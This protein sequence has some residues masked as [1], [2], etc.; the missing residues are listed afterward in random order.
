MSSITLFAAVVSV[1]VAAALVWLYIRLFT[2]SGL[3]EFDA[4]AWQSFSAERYSPLTRLLDNR[5][6]SFL[7]AQPGCDRRI[8]SEFRRRRLAAANGYL[9]DM[10][11]DFRQLLAIGQVLLATGSGSS[12]LREELFRQRIRFT[13]AMVR[14]RFQFALARLGLGHVDSSVLVDTF[15]ALAGAVRVQMPAASAA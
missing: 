7:M 4:T 13:S 3:F 2:Q 1:S 9:N 10:T 8:L 14:V 5:D 15:D 11:A 6:L 12:Q